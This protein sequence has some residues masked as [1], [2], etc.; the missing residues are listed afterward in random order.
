MG[1]FSESLEH[2]GSKMAGRKD[3]RTIRMQTPVTNAY[4]IHG[5]HELTHEVE[6]EA[7]VAECLNSGLWLYN[8]MRVFKSVLEVVLIL[9]KCGDAKLARLS[10]LIAGGTMR[11][12]P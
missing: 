4:L 1:L 12:N 8:H 2:K 7:G 3:L 11:M 9:H 5:I 10:A 6:P